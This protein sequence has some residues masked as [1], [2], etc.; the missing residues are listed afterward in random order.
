[1]N[2]KILRLS[3]TILSTLTITS[4]FL[5]TSN[6]VVYECT[7]DYGFNFKRKLEDFWYLMKENP[8][9]SI[10]GAIG[11]LLTAGTTLVAGI[12][13]FSKCSSKSDKNTAP[14]ETVN[15]NNQNIV[16][17]ENPRIENIV[18]NKN[19]IIDR[20]EEEEEE[21]QL[22]EQPQIFEEEPVDEL[23]EFQPKVELPLI[24]EVNQNY[25]PRR[26]ILE[27]DQKDE[28]YLIEELLRSNLGVRVV[29]TNDRKICCIPI[30]GS[31]QNYR[32][33]HATIEKNGDS[34]AIVI[35]EGY[36]KYEGVEHSKYKKPFSDKTSEL[37]RLCFEE[38]GIEMYFKINKNNLRNPIPFVITSP[39]NNAS[40][41]HIRSIQDQDNFVK[42]Q[43]NNETLTNTFRRTCAKANLAFTSSL[44]F[45]ILNDKSNLD[46][47]QLLNSLEGIR[48]INYNSK[49]G[50]S[51]S[52]RLSPKN[53]AQNPKN[54]KS[55][56]ILYDFNYNNNF[57]LSLDSDLWEV[58]NCT[59]GKRIRYN[60]TP[61]RTEVKLYVSKNKNICI[62]VRNKKLLEK[63]NTRDVKSQDLI[64]LSKDELSK[65][66]YE[67]S[68]GKRINCIG[69]SF[70][71][72]Y[73]DDPTEH[74][75]ICNDKHKLESF[76]NFRYSL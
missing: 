58:Y 7:C 63:I 67:N 35:P 55:F 25:D 71:E 37:K 23:K 60:V 13:L 70:K 5:N 36:E 43:I 9:K 46:N 39:I 24:N 22:E 47:K 29:N 27:V 1:M 72:E 15:Q 64:L 17:E 3:A 65:Q 48:L 28:N 74:V 19:I 2:K 10:G 68:K 56:K 52:R 54:N 33:Q 57:S 40:Y 12:V 62:I 44:S 45:K 50:A 38:Q 42:N 26:I 18:P 21:I 34:Y 30:I 11:T 53:F 75:Y 49:N 41:I 4:A 66:S 59:E 6:A 61:N 20:E 69:L 14:T 8:K 73:D 51:S 32:E 31:G 76:L 16:E